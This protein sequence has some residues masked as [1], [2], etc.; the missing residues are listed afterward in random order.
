MENLCPAACHGLWGCGV[1]GLDFS[2][3]KIKLVLCQT[4]GF[5]PL[6]FCNAARFG[7]FL[8]LVSPRAR[9]LGG[10]RDGLGFLAGNR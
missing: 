9:V 4:R 8:A 3:S 7:V 6:I 5:T 1:K 10:L 2:Q